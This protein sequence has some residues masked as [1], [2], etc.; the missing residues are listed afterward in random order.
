MPLVGWQAPGS[1]RDAR[2]VLRDG[3]GT[4]PATG[5]RSTPAVMTDDVRERAW[6][7]VHDTVATL[8]AGP[9]GPC[10]YHGDGERSQ[11]SAIDLRQSEQ[12]A[13]CGAITGRGPTEI[14]AL[15]AWAALPGA[16]ATR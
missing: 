16:S 12:Y 7:A 9:V 4:H 14:A 11:L 2:P 8:R 5:G 1:A 15:R 6:A 10:V 13:K 3:A